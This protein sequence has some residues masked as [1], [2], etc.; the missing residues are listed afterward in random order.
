M[1]LFDFLQTE[2]QENATLPL[3]QELAINFDT[4]EIL[5]ENNEVK[6]V[7]GVEAVKVWV[8]KALKTERKTYRAYSSNFG[9]DLQKEIG[10]TYD[11]TVKDQLVTNEIIDCL[12]VNPYITRVYDFIL[13]LKDSGQTLDI[14]FYM[15]TIYGAAKQEVKDVFI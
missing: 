6:T 13:D 3:M 5:A 9:N 7:S 10:Y 15:D 1:G 8:W 12:M 11:R 14:S 4:G 2:T